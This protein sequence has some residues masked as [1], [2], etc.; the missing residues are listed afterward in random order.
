MTINDIVIPEI[1]LTTCTPIPVIQAMEKC[2]ALIVRGVLP[3]E[4]VERAHYDARRALHDPYGYVSNQ[5]FSQ[6]TRTGYTPPGGEGKI[7]EGPNFC[8]HFFDYR[9][10]IA[11][12]DP[13]RDVLLPVHKRLVWL[14][15][16]LL[17]HLDAVT[18]LEL[19][20]VAWGGPHILRVAEC[21]NDSVDPKVVLFPSHLD[22]SLIT[23]FVG[24]SSPGLE[25]YVG[26]QWLPVNL[27]PGD[28]L[29]GAGTVL[30]QYRKWIPA[31]RHRLVAS[32]V[33]RVSLFQFVEPSPETVLPSGE[34]AE[35][36]F[37]RLT[38]GLRY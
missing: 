4:D 34:L 29:V 16:R 3:V 21:L 5:P 17:S 32:S 2:G 15:T 19:A 37:R 8:R 20:S 14:S 38:A 33:R 9:Q 10:G 35:E 7:G 36:F 12:L 18:G 25:V 22:F 11:A 30:T 31:L 26:D 13:N 6:E 28:V 1:L 23:F 24:G 27:A